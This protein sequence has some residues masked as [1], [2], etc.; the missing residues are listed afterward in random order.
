M[1]I[2]ELQ[3]H[4]DAILDAEAARNWYAERSPFAARGFLLALE[5]AVTAIVEAP[6]RSPLKDDGCRH[7]LFPS[8]YP[9]TLVYRTT[10]RLQVAAI[11]H[12]R[13]RPDYWHA[14]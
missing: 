2:G 1:A 4:P 7:H 9:Y 3:W 14:R 8:R 10:P 11:A 13:R 5:Q 6:D 12:Q